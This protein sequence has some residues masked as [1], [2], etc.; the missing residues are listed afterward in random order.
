MF[1]RHGIEMILMYFSFVFSR[2]E[3]E[4]VELDSGMD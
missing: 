2:I 1:A 4:G 3:G